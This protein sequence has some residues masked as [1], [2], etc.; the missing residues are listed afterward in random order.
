MFNA[1]VSAGGCIVVGAG[2]GGSGGGC[3]C[4]VAGRLP[5]STAAAAAAAVV[6]WP[7]RLRFGELR[8]D[9]DTEVV[10][11][12]LAPAISFPIAGDAG[13]GAIPMSLRHFTPGIRLQSTIA[14]SPYC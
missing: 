4:P 8:V 7:N 1:V 14:W 10:G 13:A 2:A 3:L 9:D 11:A 5:F 6:T 12:E